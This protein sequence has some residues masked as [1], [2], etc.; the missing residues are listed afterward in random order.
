VTK[1]GTVAQQ[2]KA[3]RQDRRLAGGPPAIPPSV[4]LSTAAELLAAGAIRLVRSRLLASAQGGPAQDE[5]ATA[6]TDGAHGSA[7]RALPGRG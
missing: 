3:R 6:A 5:D 1:H 2:G 7:R 4:R